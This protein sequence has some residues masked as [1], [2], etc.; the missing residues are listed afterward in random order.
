MWQHI[1]YYRHDVIVI[2]SPSDPSLSICSTPQARGCPTM[3]T[4]RPCSTRMVPTPGERGMG[5]EAEARNTFFKD[6]YQ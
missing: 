5:M 2:L 1:H 3:G 6:D 4:F